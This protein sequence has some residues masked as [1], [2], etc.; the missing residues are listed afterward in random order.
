MSE[1]EQDV[2]ANYPASLEEE[3]RLFL[4]MTVQDDDLDEAV[5]L[6][7]K[8]GLE[9]GEDTTPL[10]L[11]QKWLRDLRGSE[12]HHCQ[13]ILDLHSQGKS[14]G[15]MQALATSVRKEAQ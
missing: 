12:K 2:L 9:V 8:Y 7:D 15:G 11:C 13:N 10:G 5:R 4:Q 3:D 6:V 1:R 14:I